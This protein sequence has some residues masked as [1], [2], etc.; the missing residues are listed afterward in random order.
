MTQCAVCR[1]RKTKVKKQTTVS[2][3]MLLAFKY[4]CMVKGNED[5]N[6]EANDKVVIC[7]TCKM[8]IS[9]E[10]QNPTQLGAID[11]PPIPLT[12]QVPEKENGSCFICGNNNPTFEA[13][14]TTR[15]SAYILAELYIEKEEKICLAHVDNTTHMLVPSPELFQ[16]ETTEQIIMMS[17]EEVQD[18]MR[19]QRQQANQYR[20][21]ERTMEEIMTGLEDDSFK[22]TFG[23]KKDQLEHLYNYVNGFKTAAGLK[24]TRKSLMLLLLKLRQASSLSFLKALFGYSSL[25]A[26][27]AQIRAAREAVMSRFVGNYLGPA[28]LTRENALMHMTNLARVLHLQEGNDANLVLTVDGTY[29]YLPKSFNF[30]DLKRTFSMHKSRHLVKMTMC[31]LPDGYILDAQG[32]YY[33]DSR[34]NDAATLKDNLSR[35]PHG[36]KAFLQPGDVIIVDRGYRDCLE[37]LEELGLETEMPRY[38][39]R[40]EKQH[41]TEDANAS[42]LV[43]KTR[44]IV[45]SRNGH[46][47]TIFKFF[48]KPIQAGNIP[49]IGDYFKISCAIIN[50]Y[51]PVI[52]C[53]DDTE[54]AGKRLLELR[55]QVN[56]V[57]EYVETN[58]LIRRNSQ[59]EKMQ[60]ELEDFPRM[61]VEDL[62]DLTHG[63][64]QLKQAAAYNAE[65]E[66]RSAER[67]FEVAKVERTLLKARLYSRHVGSKE[68]VLFIRFVPNQNG[69]EGI[70]GWYCKCITGSRTV[71]MCSHICAVLWYLAIDRYEPTMRRP[72]RRLLGVA[73]DAGNRE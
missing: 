72:T 8:L 60:V 46:L 15:V 16:L 58:N 47:K 26:V 70:T 37:Y 19:E 27:S 62:L 3:E 2:A 9:R 64:Y 41:S 45:E 11:I 52:R 73:L 61:S 40:G 31:V 55:N 20:N 5:D 4:A 51:R 7:R 10:Q 18:W 54:E 17:H 48:D 34:N 24:C 12:F 57:R 28:H 6:V 23:I 30:T 33:A 65:V 36:L 25:G 68:Y 66:D 43:T 22:D 71:G 69:S 21:Q 56:E 29:I 42:R 1:K 67:I 50:A 63:V 32:P 35:N 44:W 59:W 38:P 39:Q 53:K 13:P 14:F 49:F